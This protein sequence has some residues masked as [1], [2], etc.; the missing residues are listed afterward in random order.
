M[1][2]MTTVAQILS[3]APEQQVDLLF[4]ESIGQ[5][6]E[7]LNSESLTFHWRVDIALSISFPEQPVWEN[8]NRYRLL[9]RLNNDEAGKLANKRSLET[10]S[11][12]SNGA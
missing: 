3:R 12:S 10:R 8:T 5:Y 2:Q 6:L 9:S 7:V 1:L 11:L 4:P